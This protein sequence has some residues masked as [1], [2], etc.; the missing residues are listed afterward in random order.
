MGL[1]PYILPQLDEAPALLSIFTP[2]IPQ[3]A[4]QQAICSQAAGFKGYSIKSFN[5]ITALRIL[6]GSKPGQQYYVLVGSQ[7]SMQID[8]GE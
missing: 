2:V 6:S 7:C 8:A 5:T 3:D 4:A 1:R